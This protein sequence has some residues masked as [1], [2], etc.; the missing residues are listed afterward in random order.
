MWWD[1]K[2][3]RCVFS[4]CSMLKVAINFAKAGSWGK[5]AVQMHKFCSE[6]EKDQR[7]GKADNGRERKSISCSGQSASAAEPEKTESESRTITIRAQGS[8]GQD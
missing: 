3:R 5:G 7:D 1:I 8:W 6:Q 2:R 4:D